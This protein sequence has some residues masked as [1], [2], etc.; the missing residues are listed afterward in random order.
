MNLLDYGFMVTTN[1]KQSKMK[2]LS[3]GVPIPDEF[4]GEIKL[5]HNGTVFATLKEN[6]E[7]FL[8]SGSVPI[9]KDTSKPNKCYLNFILEKNRIYKKQ[10]REKYVMS[11][12][13][14]ALKNYC[15]NSY[16]VPVFEEFVTKYFEM[17]LGE[18]R[19]EVDV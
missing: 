4:P 6:S 7:N 14:M 17:V 1:K 15:K 5:Y 13:L 3:D 2:N 8:I 18:K 12:I 16:L 19:N 9:F 10:G 11:G